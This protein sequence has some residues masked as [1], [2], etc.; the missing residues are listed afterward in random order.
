[1]ASGD[2]L[3]VGNGAREHAFVWKLRQ[4]PFV[5]S[6]YVAPGNAG[7]ACI[8]DNISID[9]T[10]IN[11]LSHFAREKD[12]DL[13]VVGP[14]LPLK[15]GIVDLFQQNGLCIFGPTAS[16]SKIETSKVFAK[17][18]MVEY[19]IPTAPFRLFSSYQEAYAY[20]HERDYPLVVKPDD[21]TG[22]KGVEVCKEIIQAEIALKKIMLDR[23]YGDAGNIVIIEDCL[24]GREVSIHTLCSKNTRHTLIPIQDNKTLGDSDTG[25]NTGGMGSYA[26]VDMFRDNDLFH[27]EQIII[28]PILTALRQRGTPFTGCLYTGLMVT[29]NGPKVLEFNARFGDP[30]TQPLMVLFANDLFLILQSYARV[31]QEIQPIFTNNQHAV[32]VNLCSEKYPSSEHKS[33]PIYGIKQA[34][35]LSDKITIFHGATK[36]IDGQLYTNGGRILSVTAVGDSLEKAASLAYRVCGDKYIHFEGMQYRMDIAKV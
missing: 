21:L 2:V 26:P 18:L 22:G 12:I 4:S 14:E 23:V 19:G 20:I 31:E 35:D 27:V 30:E 25:P 7:T 11:T 17:N 1:M 6:I 3:V 10:D 15:L 5:K 9:I 36:L 29:A 32:C 33:V 13:T 8:A 34:H 16:A 24:Q 28:D